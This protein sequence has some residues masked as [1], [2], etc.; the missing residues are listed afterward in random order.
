M[1][2]VMNLA[3]YVAVG[4]H[5]RHGDIFTVISFHIVG[6]Y[7]LVLIV[8]DVV[9]RIGRTRA[10]AIG[11]AVMAAS[12]ASLVWLT[13]IG[14][15]SVSLFGLGL[16]WNLAFVAASTELVSRGAVR[17]GAPGRLLRPAL[18]LRRR[19]ARARRR[20][21]LHR[22]RVGAAC[23]LRDCPRGLPACWIVLVPSAVR[24]ASCPP[25]LLIR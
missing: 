21:D 4:H 25:F 2:G 17:A 15:M 7:G 10:M 5:H 8:G 3:G 24:R 12:N 1:V 22:G 14:G 20:P 16:G 19:G 11:L 13:G 9:E 18:E 23:R 6:M